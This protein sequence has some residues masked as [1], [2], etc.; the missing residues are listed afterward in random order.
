MD[1]NTIICPKYKAAILS[2]PNCT[3]RVGNYLTTCEDQILCDKENCAWWNDDRNCC[4]K[5]IHH[6]GVMRIAYALAM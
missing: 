3:D 5:K 1:E 4:S 6:V 2:N